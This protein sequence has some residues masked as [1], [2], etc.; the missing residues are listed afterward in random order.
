LW[1]GARLVSAPPS[2]PLV[3]AFNFGPAVQADVPVGKLVESILELWPGVWEQEESAHEP[4][5]AESLSLAIDKA[6][7][8]LHWLPTWSFSEAIRHTVS[9][10][11]QRHVVMRDDMLAFCRFQVESF[12]AAAR[13]RGI[14]WALVPET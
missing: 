13:G 9:W 6:A 8:L 11:H 10:Y 5:E 4:H 14:P 2:S 12:A 7:A 3:G 1:L